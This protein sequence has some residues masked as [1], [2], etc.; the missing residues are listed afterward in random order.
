MDEYVLKLSSLQGSSC[1]VSQVN[2]PV[3]QFNQT[4]ATFVLFQLV[5]WPVTLHISHSTNVAAQ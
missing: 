2:Q 3:E 1:T 4:H 5:I